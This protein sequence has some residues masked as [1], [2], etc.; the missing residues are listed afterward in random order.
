MKQ[1][2]SIASFL[3]GLF[4]DPE[5]GG[6]MLLRNVGW[7]YTDYTTLYQKLGLFY[8]TTRRYLPEEYILH[9]GRRENLISHMAIVELFLT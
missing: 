7:L 9:P 5:D 4:I 1:V 3:L 2:A 6:D 8:L